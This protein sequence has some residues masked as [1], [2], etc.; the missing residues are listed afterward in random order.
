MNFSE[1]C[2]FHPKQWE[3]TERADKVGFFLFGGA[4]G[5]GKSYWLRWYLLRGLLQFAALGLRNVRAGLFCEDFPTL[6]LRQ[7]SKIKYEF[8]KWLGAIRGSQ[9]EGFGF[10]LKPEYGGGVLSFF[11]LDDASKYRGVE[12]A[13]AG[14]DELT[15]NKMHVDEEMTLFDTL[16]SCLR[17]PG[18]ERP[19]FIAATNPNGVGQKWVRQLWV[20]NNFAED[21]K[22]LAGMEAQFDFLPALAED[23]PSLPASYHHTLATLPDKLKRAWKHGDWYVS[24]E[25]LVFGEEFTQ[26]NVALDFDFDPALPVEWAIDDGYSDPRA[27][28]LIQKQGSRVLVFDEIYH[29]K[30]L[31]ETCVDEMLRR[32]LQHDFKQDQPAPPAQFQHLDSCTMPDDCSCRARRPEVAIVSKEDVELQRR[33]SNVGIASRFTSHQVVERVALL[34]SLF[35]DGKGVRTIFVHPRCQKLLW[36]L[37]EGYI[38]PT[39]KK[40]TDN[41][42]PQDGNDHAIEALGKWAMARLR[43]GVGISI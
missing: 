43:G 25:G 17:W 33:L 22:H 38:Y 2:R 29:T 11:N 15:M 23:N 26:N 28:L 27:I 6:R 12:M 7:I 24:F 13:L 34:R 39:G 31:A 9:S 19:Q 18:V 37:T 3:A 30:H 16:R 5:P 32:H 10:F 4:K 35:C 36:E 8:P 14:I 1:L 41:E 20:E 42:K 21:W 40:A